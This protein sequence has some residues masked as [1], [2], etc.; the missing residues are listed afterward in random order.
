MQ[1]ALNL[2]EYRRWIV[3]LRKR[4]RSTQIKAA[5]SVNAALLEFY[6]ELGR[7]ISA[8]YP[9]KR[10]NAHFFE[11]LSVD[12]QT[13]IED[14]KGLSERNIRYALNFF[15]LYAYLPQ[16]AANSGEASSYLPQVVADKDKDETSFA[17]NVAQN[18][19]PLIECLIRI[20]WGHHR[21]LIDKN[22]WL[23]K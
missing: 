9:G 23:T 1:A 7:D 10:R 22:G 12:R 6:W 18:D 16:L 17:K 15:E 20:P 11:N 3:E 13:D 2:D 14:P 4:Y 8:K 5:I 19:S 21:C